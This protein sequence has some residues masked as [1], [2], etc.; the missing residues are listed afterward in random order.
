M[1][2]QRLYRDCWKNN[3]RK[4]GMTKIKFNIGADKFFLFVVVSIVNFDGIVGM[5]TG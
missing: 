1:Y 2:I 5:T 3:R 4:L